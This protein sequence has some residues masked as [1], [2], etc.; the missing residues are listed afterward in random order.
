M[1][2]R[3]RYFPQRFV[4][5]RLRLYADNNKIP[6]NFQPDIPIPLRFKH[7]RSVL[8]CDRRIQLRRREPEELQTKIRLSVPTK[9][10]ISRLRLCVRQKT[11]H[12]MRETVETDRFLQRNMR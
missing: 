1:R 4:R 12:R 5:L 6:K 3:R 2:I 9:N 11:T 8:Q 10:R 7:K